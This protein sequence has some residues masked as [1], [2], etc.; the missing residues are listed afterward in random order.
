MHEL[1]L[2]CEE[3]NFR[4]FL[5][6]KTSLERNLSKQIHNQNEKTS[7]SIELEQT[8]WIYERYTKII[9]KGRI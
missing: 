6:S 3:V 4:F 8:D 7:R 9:H 5:F 2:T 1:I